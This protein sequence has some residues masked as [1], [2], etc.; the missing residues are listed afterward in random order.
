VRGELGQWLQKSE[1]ATA[2]ILDSNTRGAAL[3]PAPF[4][5]LNISI[6][7]GTGTA[8][9][10]ASRRCASAAMAAS[11]SQPR[12][13]RPSCAHAM[14]VVP[15]PCGKG[16]AKD[17]VGCTVV[18]SNRGPVRRPDPLRSESR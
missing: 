12:K 7:P 6:C 17:R 14:P 10:P 11:R 5:Y 16:Q 4:L 13:R 18:Q 9:S 3:T 1:L 15:L 8:R 2:R